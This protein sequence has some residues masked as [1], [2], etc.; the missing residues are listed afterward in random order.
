MKI[1]FINPLSYSVFPVQIASLSGFLKASGYE[2]SY[3]ELILKKDLDGKSKIIIAARVNDFRP[4]LIGISSY[5]LTFEWVKQI[6]DYVKS[7]FSIPI[8][9][10]G[11]H[12][13]LAPE[14]V[15]N[16][17]TVDIICRGEGEYPLLNLLEDMGKDRNNY[18]IKN[19]WFKK[20]GKIIKNKIRPL[21]ID[22]DSLPFVDRDILN[23]QKLLDESG[24]KRYL[25]VMGS[26]GCPYNCSNCSNHALQSIYPNKSKYVRLRSVDNIIEEIKKALKKYS[27]EGVSF[28]DDTFT[29]YQ[30]W[31]EEFCIKYKKEI[32]LNFRCNARPENSSLENIKL[33][34]L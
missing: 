10:G 30:K 1:L 15:I 9:I 12:A 34:I 22:L 8:I 4:D 33:L 5:Q 29:L 27:F 23:Y 7:K 24:E 26:R 11:Y 17:S 31:L 14:E 2:T 16:Y 32:G 20:G 25:S 28:E 3:L 13:T 19:L 6:C 21:I 18:K